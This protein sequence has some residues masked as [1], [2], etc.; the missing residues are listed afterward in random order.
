MI[1]MKSPARVVIASA[2]LIR[3]EALL[4]TFPTSK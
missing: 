3:A 4:E 1:S 2:L